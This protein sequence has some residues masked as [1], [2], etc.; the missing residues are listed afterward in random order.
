MF[1]TLL[2]L[3]V[4]ISSFLLYIILH[5]IN[6]NTIDFS[7][8]YCYYDKAGNKYC[9]FSNVCFLSESGGQFVFFLAE[10]STVFGLK[11][12]EDLNNISFS[13]VDGHN[14]FNM[15]IVMSIGGDI[16]KKSKFIKNSVFIMSRFKSD[17]TM[18]VIHDDIF[19]LFV[20]YNFMCAGNVESCTKTHRLA[21]L[22]N[23][24]GIESHAEWYDLFSSEP[25]LNLKALKESVCF[26]KLH[27]GLSRESLW[28]Q[29]GFKKVQG[30][31]LESS[32]N[33]PV[34]RKFRNFIL[35]GFNIVRSNYYRPNNAVF[36]SRKLSRKIL[37]ENYVIESISKSFDESN[38]N[39]KNGFTVKVVDA[40][41]N[42]TKNI[43]ETI[44]NC[45][46]LVGMHGSAMIFS[47]FLPEG[48]AI[49]ELFPFGIQPE[50]VSPIR[51]LAKLPGTTFSYLSWI[52]VQESNSVDPNRSEALMG[53]LHH[54]N[55]QQQSAIK[56]VKLVPAVECCHDP[57]YLYRMF[58]DTVVDN[59]FFQ[60][61][62]QLKSQQENLFNFNNSSNS[63]LFLKDKWLFPG[64]VYDIKCDFLKHNKIIITWKKPLNFHSFTKHEYSITIQI[65]S[66]I[67]SVK[68]F[69]TNVTIMENAAVGNI[70]VW[71]KCMFDNSE[72]IDSF[73]VC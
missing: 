42:K 14:G 30:P 67:I 51:A 8:V 21:F 11:S 61:L 59:S 27:T 64:S 18:H 1:R 36:I 31:I 4:M 63:S 3:T 34:L 23:D 7:S 39:I 17:N 37:N 38:A 71:I 25:P 53:G 24:I 55:P 52:N 5:N 70:Q 29:Y 49:L 58:Q 10:Q 44:R 46:V 41:Q 33:G 35:K 66:R 60:S 40:M 48:A 32:L 56:A 2:S 72:S 9:T 26:R 22:D 13:S 16:L 54:L 73:S 68:T 45:K 28:F 69:T 19:P 6:K 15:K 50:H 20:T 65:L 62:L 57:V 43:L 12:K 47:L